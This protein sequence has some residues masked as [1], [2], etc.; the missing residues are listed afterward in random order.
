MAF[1]VAAALVCMLLLVPVAHRLTSAVVGV[2]A[3]TVLHN[4][5]LSISELT[6][7]YKYNFFY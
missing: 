1:G 3:A 4:N 6:R 7:R 5:N 2:V